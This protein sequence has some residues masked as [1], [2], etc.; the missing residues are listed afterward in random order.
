MQPF[1]SKILIHPGLGDS[2][3]HHWQTVWE[4]EYGFVRVKQRDWDTPDCEEWIRILDE[5]VRGAG[6]AVIIVG[7][8]LACCTIAN[9]SARFQTPLTAALL[10]APSDTEGESY[11]PGTTG[12][13]PMPLNKLRFPSVTVT[14]TDDPYVSLARAQQFSDCWGSRKLVK[15]DHAGH[16][17]VASGFG[18]WPEGLRLL[19]ELDGLYGPR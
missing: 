12:F 5:Y 19:H 1:R 10:V 4:R 17:N 14:S 8:S 7:H 3:E 9:W 15:I 13:T 2:G 16:I 18:A 6:D 11:P